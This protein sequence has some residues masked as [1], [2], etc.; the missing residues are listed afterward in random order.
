MSPSFPK[1]SEVG[2]NS[3][4]FPNIL[5]NLALLTQSD[6]NVDIRNVLKLYACLIILLI[7]IEKS[8]FFLADH[9]RIDFKHPHHFYH[10]VKVIV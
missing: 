1:F 10:L 2:N 6:I 7:E 3:H 8:E 4:N 9:K 5:F